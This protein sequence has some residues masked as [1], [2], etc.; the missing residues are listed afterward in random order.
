[1]LLREGDAELMLSPEWWE[2]IVGKEL[3]MGS[4]LGDREHNGQSMWCVAAQMVWSSR[5]TKCT[6]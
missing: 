2:D 6:I 3:Q 1:M 4:Q 5:G